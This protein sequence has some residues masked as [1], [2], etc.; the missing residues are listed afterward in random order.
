MWSFLVVWYYKILCCIQ[1]QS[2]I[3]F[4]PFSRFLPFGLL[5]VKGFNEAFLI[6]ISK[7]VDRACLCFLFWQPHLLLIFVF[8]FFICTCTSGFRYNL[9]IFFSFYS[10]TRLMWLIQAIWWRCLLSACRF[11]RYAWIY[12][13]LLIFYQ[14]FI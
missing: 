12:T 11:N 10:H 8:H 9:C 13:Y 5:S 2:C 14:P 3:F 7:W 6:S 1:A 4:F